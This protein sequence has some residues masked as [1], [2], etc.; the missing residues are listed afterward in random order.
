VVS[1]NPTSEELAVV[2][3]VLQAAAASAA[4]ARVAEGSKRV[5]HWHRNAGVLRG[6]ILP[7]HGQ[8]VASTRRG[9]Y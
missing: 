8:W 4:A 2:V 5:A 7:G 6:A 1:G 9:L 3:A